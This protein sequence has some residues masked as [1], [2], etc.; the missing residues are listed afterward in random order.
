MTRRT[1]LLTCLI[2]SREIVASGQG[3]GISCPPGQPNR[4][5]IT[6]GSKPY[7]I[8]SLQVMFEGKI[9]NF[10]SQEIW[11]TLSVK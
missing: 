7:E 3:I 8:G 9:L 6:L 5:V 2:A 11:D 1:A 4:L 10:T